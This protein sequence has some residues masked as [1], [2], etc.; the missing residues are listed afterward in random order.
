LTE[1]SEKEDEVAYQITLII[2][3][4]L[5]WV[6]LIMAAVALIRAYAGLFGRREW[7]DADRKVGL[8]FSAAMDVQLLLGLALY[9][10]LSPLTRTIFQD[11]GAAMQDETIR[12]FAIE[13][14]FYM[15]VAVA[16]VHIGNSRAKKATVSRTKY[17]NAAMFYSL[18]VLLILI[19]MPWFR[20][21]LRGFVG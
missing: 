14:L 19:A 6:V 5:R 21:L 12:F 16:L 1:K 11:F 13:H 4:Y 17:R 3:N 2:H 8:F 15:L 20:P 10:F 18:A 7:G 9:F